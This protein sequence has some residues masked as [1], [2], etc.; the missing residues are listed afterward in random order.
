MFE[1]I[2]R[3]AAPGDSLVNEI[4]RREW[5][6]F[7][8]VQNEGGRAACQ[9]DAWTFY[10][11]RYSQFA[12]LSEDVL[13]SYRDDLDQAAREGRNL[14]FEKYAYMMEYTDPRTF[15]RT[16][17]GRIPAISPY[18]NELVARVAN[19]LIAS[20]KEF[21]ACY[22]KLHQKGR[23]TEG[24]N[25][26][27]VSAH[28]YTLGELKTYSERTLARYDAHL[29]ARKAQGKENISTAVH[30]IMVS[31]YGYSSLEAAEARQT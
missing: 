27:N 26:D 6:M 17:K 1:R 10:V 7:D 23:P 19:A 25:A 30:R 11:M 24:L 22:P 8:R 15:D 31:F 5:Q 28:V 2:Q 21:A 16:L 14:L 18:K 29:H 20:E 13:E 3:T 12:P 9:D 4:I